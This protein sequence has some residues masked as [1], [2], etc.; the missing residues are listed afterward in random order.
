MGGEETGDDM[1]RQIDA[2]FD[3]SNNVFE[4]ESGKE[5][6]YAQKASK[7]KSTGWVTFT[8]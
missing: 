1:I 5:L 4:L 2:M 8:L 7:G 6:K 3:I